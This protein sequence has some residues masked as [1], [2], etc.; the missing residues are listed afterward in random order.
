M[1]GVEDYLHAWQCLVFVRF[2]SLGWTMFSIQ[3]FETFFLCQT[4]TLCAPLNKHFVQHCFH[5]LFQMQGLS[6]SWNLGLKPGLEFQINLVTLV[7]SL[8][9]KESRFA[10]CVGNRSRS[11]SSKSFLIVQLLRVILSFNSNHI[12]LFLWRKICVHR[13]SLESLDSYKEDFAT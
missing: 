4:D 8:V 12:T 5:C 2:L 7:L 10:R 11:R 1:Q 9:L 3:S 13:I 6:E